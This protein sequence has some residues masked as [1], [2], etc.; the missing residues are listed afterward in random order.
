MRLTH[1]QV[2]VIKEQVAAHFGPRAEVWLFGSRVDDTGRGG[3]I[4][5]YIET[6]LRPEQFLDREMRLYAQLQRRFGE[7]H[8]DI[9]THSAGAPLRAIHRE[10]RA[11]GV[12]L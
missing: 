5:L 1:E 11:T 3:D 8:I 10:A 2:C 4:D 9:V 12:P 6:D 7:R